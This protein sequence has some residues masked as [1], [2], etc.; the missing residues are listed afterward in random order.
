MRNKNYLYGLYTLLF[1]IGALLG[2]LMRAQWQIMLALPL[3]PKGN[4]DG[5]IG[6]LTY[7]CHLMR[8]PLLIFCAGFTLFAPLAS[9][10]CAML[11][12]VTVGS[13]GGT[14]DAS[15][16]FAQPDM[17]HV[18]GRLLLALVLTLYVI[19]CGQATAHRLSLRT[20]APTPG[21]ILRSAESRAYI[22]FFFLLSALF[23]AVSA[24]AVCLKI[25]L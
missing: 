17:A 18:V 2:W 25:G 9:G 24:V 23:L 21:R 20:A 5:W 1:L 14:W 11:V 3:I 19:L 16:L 7:Y 15:L 22:S 4:G 12:G 8:I 13:G 10:L 6:V